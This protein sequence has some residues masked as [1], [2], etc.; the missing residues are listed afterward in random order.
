[1]R[2]HW[3]RL[4]RTEPD[5]EPLFGLV[6]LTSLA[7][8]WLA[9]PH[10]GGVPVGCVFKAVSGWPCL[11]CGGTRALAALAAGEVL[12]A[13]RANPLVCGVGLVAGAWTPLALASALFG[14]PRLRVSAG[15]RVAAIARVTVAAIAAACWVYLV[16][17]GR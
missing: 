11:T 16:L 13:A 15:R 14:W 7:L 10:L 4:H 9:A 6:A 3:R 12:Q 2:W 8:G 1:M 17:D 5:Y